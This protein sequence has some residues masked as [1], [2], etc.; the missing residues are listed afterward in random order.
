LILQI[1][2]LPIDISCIWKR[3]L[4]KT[5]LTLECSLIKYVNSSNLY[6]H[7]VDIHFCVP[8]KFS[9]R[10]LGAS[11]CWESM[12]RSDRKEGERERREGKV[13]GGR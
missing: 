3:T 2:G 7:P 4:G 5:A 10:S 8:P 13:L 1:T 12:H 9:A 11:V 6:G